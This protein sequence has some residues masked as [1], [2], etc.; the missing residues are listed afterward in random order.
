LQAARARA[1][2]AQESSVTKATASSPRGDE[3]VAWLSHCKSTRW[4]LS[5]SRP[6]PRRSSHTS[7]S[8]CRA[9]SD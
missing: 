8:S 6:A 7:S 3:A 9:W 2:H 1:M 4:A 5:W